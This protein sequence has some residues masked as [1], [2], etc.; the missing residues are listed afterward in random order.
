MI[1]KLVIIS[2]IPFFFAGCKKENSLDCFKSNGREVSEI[3]NPGS[4]SKVEVNEKMEV[5][6]FKGTEFKVEVIAGK[7]IIKNIKTRL[8]NDTLKIEN[9][10]TCNFVRGYKKKV[11]VN[12]TLPYLHGI[13]HNGVAA[14]VIDGSF[15]QDSIRVDAESS[16]DVFLNGNY[17]FINSHSNGNGDVTIQGTCKSLNVYLNGTNF[18]NAENLKVSDKIYIVTQSLGDSHINALDLKKMEYVIYNNGNIYYKGKP[19][20]LSG[21][22]DS[23]AKGKLIPL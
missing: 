1:K 6:V 16:G 13:L 21:V 23:K 9:K 20:S 12:V 22:L 4:F 7:N 11:R 14:L 8:V 3:R 5:T 19:L 2:I 10:N 18:F 17:E 15:N